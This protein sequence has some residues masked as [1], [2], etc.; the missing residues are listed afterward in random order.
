[1]TESIVR[2]AFVIAMFA[3]APAVAQIPTRRPVIQPAGFTMWT[4]PAATDTV[5]DAT[6]VAPPSRSNTDRTA[7]FTLCLAI[8]PRLAQLASFDGQLEFPTALASFDSVSIAPG[9]IGSAILTSPGVIHITASRPSG[10]INGGV[11]AVRLNLLH[12]GTL[13]ALV[14]TMSDVRTVSGTSAMSQV[15][16]QGKAPSR[17]SGRG[18]RQSADQTPRLISL[19]RRT[20]AGSRLTTGESVMVT[21][22]GANFD[23]V[24]NTVLFGPVSIGN[25][26]STDGTTLRF[27]VPSWRAPRAG[28]QT[29]S[30]VPDDYPVTVITT[31]GTSNV[32]RFRIMP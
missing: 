32:L 17:R 15:W 18:Q 6:I 10:L 2:R 3:A 20:I 13:P 19:D 28:G 9:V 21:I 11:L 23:R 4:C 27:T 12:P 31:R 26:T 24:D 14:L 5:Y 7:V 1:M 25:L 22:L 8:S 29:M 16:V 30:L